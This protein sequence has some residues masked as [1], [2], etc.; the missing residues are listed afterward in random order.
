[1]MAR[2]D[3]AVGDAFAF[4]VYDP[5]TGRSRVTARVAGFAKVAVPAGAEEAARIEYRID[6][7]RGAETYEVLVARRIPRFLVK[8]RF[9]DGAVT[10]LIERPPDP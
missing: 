6:K 5:G 3:Y 4:H 1:V 2:K 7:S 8:E 9:P 10:E